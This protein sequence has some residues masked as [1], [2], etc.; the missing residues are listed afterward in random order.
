MPQVHVENS[1][2]VSVSELLATI[3]EQNLGPNRVTYQLG[4]AL[5]CQQVRLLIG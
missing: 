5:L 2:N 4:V 1:N 3:E